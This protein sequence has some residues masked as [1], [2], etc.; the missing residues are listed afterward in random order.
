MLP[1]LP[2]LMIFEKE[3]G[4]G[5][6]ENGD[7]KHSRNGEIRPDHLGSGTPSLEASQ[8]LPAQNSFLNKTLRTQ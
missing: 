3:R 8:E 1:K 7:M 4:G 6:R 2:Y 5:R